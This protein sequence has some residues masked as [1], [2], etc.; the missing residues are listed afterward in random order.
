MKN[1]NT[2]PTLLNRRRFI[3][4]SA[5]A[6][7]VPFLLNGM[8]LKA[9]D[10]PILQKLFNGDQETDR[11]LVLVQLSGG[12]DGLNTVIPL[13]Q[14]SKYMSVRSNIAIPENKALKIADDAGLHPVMTGV[15]NLFNDK[16]V[17]VV[18][19]VSYPNPN[20]SHFRATDIWNTGSA[21]NVNLQSGWLGR[22]M[23]ELYPGYPTGFPNTD[24]P[25]PIA[26]QMSA[27]V[28]LSLMG[29]ESN[30]MGIALQDPETF[31][32]LV[33]GTDAPG[34]ELPT[35]MCARE[36][37]LYVREVQV[38]S[39]E[40]STV[41]K[42]AADKATNV[43]TYPTNNRLGDQLKIVARLIAGGLKTR[44]YVV[45]MGGFDTHAA[46]T[47][48]GDATGGSHANLLKQVSEAITTFQS[49]IEKLKV[50][51]RVVTMTYSEFGRR[52]ASNVSLG[53]DHGTAAP[54]F[55]FGLPVQDGVIGHSPSLTDLDKENLK[56]QY[57]FRQIYASVLEQWL[58]ADKAQINKV[59]FSDFQTVKVIKSSAPT[60]VAEDAVAQQFTL[61][62]ISPNPVAADVM[63]SYTMNSTSIVSLEVFDNIGFHVATVQKQEVS[64]GNYSVPF[65]VQSL[66]SGT[67][68]VQ[69][70]AGNER[71]TQ[72]MLVLR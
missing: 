28:S 38:K 7:A 8:T 50:A 43:E 22:Y 60:A 17:A 1:E 2:K 20:Q 63:F 13:D 58:G 27:V 4:R 56:M 54:M 29:Y 16:K 41:I 64:A 65:N 10:G 14:M 55:F 26:I 45:Q 35:A 69:L 53:T 66:P 70:R 25:D 12:N 61:K 39:M 62:A 48:V 52:V 47:D 31:Y 9:L 32:R 19:G 40:Y 5:G 72:T 68:M 23:N 21:S 33:S 6:M 37:V 67:Y 44:V 3:T 71:R 51:E 49:D 30:S 34:S 18:Q 57:D 15:H 42:A 36:N 24:T 11:V 59:L 46:Q